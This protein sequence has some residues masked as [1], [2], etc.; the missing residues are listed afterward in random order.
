[1]SNMV[2][3]REFTLM[4]LAG[5][6]INFHKNEPVWVPPECVGEALAIGAQ[7]V[8]EQLNILAPAELPPVE[9]TLDERKALI[10]EAFIDVI[11]QNK[12]E[13][14]TAQGVPSAP[15]ISELLGF[16][17][18][19]KERDIAWTEYQQEV[20]DAAAAATSAATSAAA[21]AAKDEAAAE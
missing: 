8:D 10:K 14:F 4:S 11:A 17:V 15:A 18:P 20:S 2:L 19:S 21:T 3:N 13:A 9:L 7:G 5:R 16:D 1:M 6:A 12:R